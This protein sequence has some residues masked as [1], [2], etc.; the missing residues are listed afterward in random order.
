MDKVVIHTV[1]LDISDILCEHTV[2]VCPCF[3]PCRFLTQ[4]SLKV[5][6]VHISSPPPAAVEGASGG[7]WSVLN[8]Q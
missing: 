3:F 1:L 4:T 2:S 6:D 8:L 5:L 7:L